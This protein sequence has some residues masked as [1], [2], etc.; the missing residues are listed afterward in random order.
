MQKFYSMAM[1]LIWTAL[2]FILSSESADISS[3]RSGLLVGILEPITSGAP[4]GILTFLI[5]K[6]AHIFLYF[7]LGVL[8]YNVVRQYTLQARK[9]IVVSIAIAC[10]Y[11][12]S[13][14]VHQTFVPGRSGEARDVLIDTT[15]ASAGVIACYGLNRRILSRK[16]MN[17]KV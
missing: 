7:V 2:I 16:R 1:L 11:A 10:T 6:S 12:I 8:I 14:E 13:D 3:Q 15:A 5:R 9:A 17:E 4:E